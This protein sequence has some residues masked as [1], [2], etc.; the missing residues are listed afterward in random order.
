LKPPHGRKTDQ[1]KLF[2]TRFKSVGSIA[3]A[4]RAQWMNNML[5]SLTVSLSFLFWR[6]REISQRVFPSK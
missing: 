6:F 4:F 3:L 5:V 1:L 2:I